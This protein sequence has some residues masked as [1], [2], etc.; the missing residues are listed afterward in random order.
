MT[1]D[2]TTISRTDGQAHA[3]RVPARRK[4]ITLRRV[5]RATFL[6]AGMV[7]AL[8]VV[9]A[10]FSWLVISSV[11][12]KADLLTKPLEWIPA[13]ISFGRF[14]D[15]TVGSSADETAQG[16]R[17]AIMNS[18]LIA[19]ATTAVGMVVGTLAAYAFA[20]LRFPGR[21]WMI[22][23]FM[24]TTMLPPIALILPLFQIMKALGLTDTPIALIIIYSSFVTPYVVWLMRGYIETIPREL[25]DAGRVDGCS[26]WRAVARHHSG[27]DSR[28]ALDRAAGV[29]A[30]LGRVPL[31]P[32]DHAV[33]CLEDAARG[34]Q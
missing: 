27:G 16:F 5:A 7:I 11:A 1:I 6:Y 9:V 15:L 24:A 34:A 32:G 31:R 14:V 29:P 20:R 33:E 17:A 3:S 30:R 26:A 10:P 25:D 23:A 28:A 12:D 19:S 18:M 8:L 22:L 13:H 2:R 21:S 4:P